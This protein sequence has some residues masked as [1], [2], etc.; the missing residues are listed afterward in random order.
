MPVQIVQ[1]LGL[2]LAKEWILRLP[3][4]QFVYLRKRL[5]EFPEAAE[6]HGIIEPISC[7]IGLLD[8]L[9]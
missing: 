8:T 3:G 7:A 2:L 4:Q 6:N 9:G 5:F 1:Y